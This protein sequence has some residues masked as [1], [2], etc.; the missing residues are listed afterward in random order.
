VNRL[1]KEEQSEVVKMEDD[2]DGFEDLERTPNQF[3][4]KVENARVR[5]NR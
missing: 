2:E 4:D 3:M 1:K 5:I